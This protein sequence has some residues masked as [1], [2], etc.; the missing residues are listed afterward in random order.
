M[1]ACSPRT[2]DTQRLLDLLQAYD[3]QGAWL[4]IC[5]R[6]DFTGQ[7]DQVSLEVVDANGVVLPDRDG[8]RCTHTLDGLAPW[9]PVVRGQSV[10]LRGAGESVWVHLLP[11]ASGV[12]LGDFFYDLRD[13]PSA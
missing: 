7:P 9:V 6:L 4:L 10:H 13:H 3:P 12:M 1:F 8:R 2:R 11:V 5:Q